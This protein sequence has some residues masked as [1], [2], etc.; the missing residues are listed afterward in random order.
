MDNVNHK[1]TEEQSVIYP[2]GEYLGR[3]FH[4]RRSGRIIK[5]PHRYDLYF[6]AAKEWNS[7]N[8]EM[9]VYMIQYEDFS[10]NV[11]MDEILSLLG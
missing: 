3:N 4:V 7:D 5:Y 1:G 10:S 8:V 6:W 9:I 2:S 11:Y